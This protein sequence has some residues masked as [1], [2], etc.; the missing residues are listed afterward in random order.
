MDF[1]AGTIFLITED[2]SLVKK[3]VA[4]RLIGLTTNQR[5]I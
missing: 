3:L 4:G 1:G 5:K 2:E